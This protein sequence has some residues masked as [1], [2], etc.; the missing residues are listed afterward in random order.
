[1]PAGIEAVVEGVDDGDMI[2]TLGAGSVSLAGEPI[3]QELRG[4]MAHAQGS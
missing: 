1:M 2:I 4:R 3:L